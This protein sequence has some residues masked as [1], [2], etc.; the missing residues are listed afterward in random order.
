MSLVNFLL[1][2]HCTLDKDILPSDTMKLR[3]H[4]GKL[5]EEL[6]P[7]AADKPY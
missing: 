7:K 5:S 2:S 3:V 1:L 6:D 4:V